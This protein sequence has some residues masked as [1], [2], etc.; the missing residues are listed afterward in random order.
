MASTTFPYGSAYDLSS[1]DMVCG[2]N[3]ELNFSIFSSG[4]VAVP[5][6]LAQVTW[7]LSPFGSTTSV[8]TKTQ[9]LSGSSNIFQVNI[10]ASDTINLP[11]GKYIQSFKILDSSGSAILPSRGCVN[12]IGAIS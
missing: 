11:G 2:S 1:F 3:Q 7:W 6:N 8:L 9:T 5:L 10:I 12:L 4:S